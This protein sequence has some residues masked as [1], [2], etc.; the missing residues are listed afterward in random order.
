M[1]WNKKLL[2]K[3]IASLIIFL[4]NWSYYNFSYR[5]IIIIKIWSDD[6]MYVQYNLSHL[7]KIFWQRYGQGLWLHNL[8]LKMQ[9]GCSQSYWHHNNFN[10]IDWKNLLKPTQNNYKL[11]SVFFSYFSWYTK[12][13]WF[14][15]KS[16]EVSKIQEVSHVINIFFRSSL[17]KIQVRQVSSLWNMKNRF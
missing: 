11:W 2:L 9:F 8:F 10:H 12:N 4:H 7:K 6:H 14:L 1:H 17:V 3:K 13:C 15:V 16:V 5:N